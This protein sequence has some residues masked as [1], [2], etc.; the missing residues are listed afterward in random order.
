[1]RGGQAGFTPAVPASLQA[2]VRREEYLL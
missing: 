1:M 2:T